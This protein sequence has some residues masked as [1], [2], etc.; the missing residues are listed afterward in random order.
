MALQSKDPGGMRP[1]AGLPKDTIYIKN[2]E[3]W[4]V[5]D[6]ASHLTEFLIDTGA[7]FWVLTQRIGNLSNHREYVMGLSG[8]RQGRTFLEPLLCNI[9]GQLI[10]HSFLF[11]PDCPIPLIGR[12][13][14]TKLGVTL[15][16]GEQGTHPHH[17]MVLT[18]N[19]EEPIESEAEVEALVGCGIWNMEIP[20]LAKDTQLRPRQ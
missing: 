4:V 15:F 10:L 5:I 12:D 13:L 2:A 20:G 18:E 3:P 19:R 11:V 9:N 17:Q 8:K 14:L 16:L 7:T 6:V 1:K